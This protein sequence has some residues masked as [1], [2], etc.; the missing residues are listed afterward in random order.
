MIQKKLTRRE[1]FTQSRLLD[2]VASAQTTLPHWMPRLAFAQ[3]YNNPTG[4]VLVVVFLRGGADSLNM[5]V[6]HGDERYYQARPRLSIPRPDDNSQP[7]KTLDLDGFFGIHPALSPLIPIFQ[8]GQIKAVHGT[9]S[10]HDTRSHFEAMDF[11]ERGTPNGFTVTSGW[12]GRHLATINNGN[13]SP[14]RG[15]GWG[16][17][18]Q[19][20]LT[21]APSTIAMKSIVDYHLNGDT[22]Q[23]ERIMQSLMTLYTVAEAPLMASAQAT[24]AAIDVIQKVDYASYIPQNGAEYPET[25]FAFALRQTAALIRA[26][27]G[28]EVACVDLGGWDT[29]NNQ[30]TTEGQQARLMTDLANGLASF[31]QDLGIDMNRVSVVVMSEFGRRVAENA[32]LGTD[33]GHGGAMLVMGGNFDFSAPVMANWVGLEP[34]ALDQN[35]DLPIT[36]DYRDILGELLMKRLR[37]VN[38]SDIFPDYTVQ[39]QN[40]FK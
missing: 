21:S 20:S 24:Q 11:M 29:H 37:N 13:E 23:A 2:K 6:P 9:G 22:Q 19:K 4:D 5:I 31:H 10:P 18:I 35:E 40:L 8:G 34:D 38:L 14:V 15:V 17:A 3:P 32:N 16:T 30:G 39:M 12:V 7:L 27:V 33:H 1:F 26:Q 25:D 28:L 36:I